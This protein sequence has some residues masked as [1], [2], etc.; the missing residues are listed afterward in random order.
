MLK[1]IYDNILFVTLL[2]LAI[3]SLHVFALSLVNI[4][5]DINNN[6]RER[7]ELIKDYNNN[8]EE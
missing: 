6:I 3:Y 2:I 4:E 8:E 5:K 7:I 1:K